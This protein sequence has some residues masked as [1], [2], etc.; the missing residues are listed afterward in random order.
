MTL[1]T[2]G[3]MAIAMSTKQSVFVKSALPLWHFL[4]CVPEPAQVI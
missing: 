2:Y 1:R 4:H 3:T